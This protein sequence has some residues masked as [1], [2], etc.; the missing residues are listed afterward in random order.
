[1]H[2]SKFILND[3]RLKNKN[4][5][6]VGCSISGAEITAS[7]VGHA[8]RV[9]NIFPRPYLMLPRLVK[10]SMDNGDTYKIWPM[11]FFSYRR[12]FTYPKEGQSPD[13]LYK[14]KLGVFKSI[15]PEQTNKNVSHPDLFVD[16][17]DP[18]QE[19]L[20]A[21]SDR[22]Y[23]YVKQ[24]K[25]IPKKTKIQRFEADGVH[26][27][28]GTFEQVDAVIYATGYDLSVDFFEDYIL[29][30]LSYDVEKNYK[31]A[32]MLYKCTFHPDISNMAIIG[33]HDGLFFTGNE[34]QSMWVTKVFSDKISLPDR[35]VMMDFIQKECNKRDS[36][37]RVQYPYGVHVSICDGIASEIGLL[38]DLNEI[39]EKEPDLFEMFSNNMIFSTQYI[40][41]E[42]RELALGLMNEI[43]ALYKKNYKFN[44][45]DVYTISLDDVTK[46]FGKHYPLPDDIFKMEN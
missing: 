35:S 15:F 20:V 3:P 45:D 9:V 13:E 12:C 30:T 21:L 28:D 29:K 27:E 24:N 6:V 34:L 14:Y 25:I 36:G 10:Y 19:V 43:D 31:H 39:K 11:D 33:Q 41:K 23:P 22:Y 7:L 16:L 4:V 37:R 2:S 44:A 5:V 18:N 40:F 26:L 42:N 38:P 32:I 46:S 8:K 1:L 17:D